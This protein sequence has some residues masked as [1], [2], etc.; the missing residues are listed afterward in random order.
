MHFQD[1]RSVSMPMI[2]IQYQSQNKNDPQLKIKIR[3]ARRKL[4]FVQ[5]QKHHHD[6]KRGTMAYIRLSI[7]VQGILTISA[8]PSDTGMPSYQSFLS[9]FLF[10]IRCSSLLYPAHLLLQ[11]ATTATS[12]S[13]CFK[14][15][16]SINEG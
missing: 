9:I 5:Y 12:I 16:A 3:S 11:S 8:C 6:L 7:S 4:V 15:Q 1:P 13:C 14:L 2:S 10:R